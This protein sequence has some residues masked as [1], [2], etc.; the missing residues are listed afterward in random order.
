MFNYS[1]I[2]LKVKENKMIKENTEDMTEDSAL[3]E[4]LESPILDIDD[5]PEDQIIKD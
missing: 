2:V 4:K 5:I 1:T 3:N